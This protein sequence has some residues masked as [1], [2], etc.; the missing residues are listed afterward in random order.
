MVGKTGAKGEYGERGPRG[1]QGLSGATFLTWKIDRK[2]YTAIPLMSDG[3]EG[4]RLYLRELFEE[5]HS[6]ASSSE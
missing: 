3:H 1:E 5:Y 6:E 2:T 4:P